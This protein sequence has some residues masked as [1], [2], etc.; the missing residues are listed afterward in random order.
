MKR[1]LFKSGYPA[2][3]RRTVL[4]FV[5]MII[6]PLPQW[7]S[8]GVCGAATYYV[9]P[10]GN[11]RNDGSSTAPFETIQKA[12]DTVR[13]G[14]TV[15]VGDGTYRDSNNDGYIVYLDRGGTSSA[16]VTFK[17]ENKWGAV[18]D[19]QNNK[20]RYCWLNYKKADYVR[21]EDFEIKGCVKGIFSN[22]EN[23]DI[24]VYRN[25]IHDIGRLETYDLDGKSAVHTGKGTYNFTFDSNVIHTIGR[26]NPYTT[27]AV[28]ESSCTTPPK[29]IYNRTVYKDL[30]TCYNHD[31]GLYL[32]GSNHKV[33]NNIFYDMKSGWPIQISGGPSATDGPNWQIMNNTFYGRN[34]RREGHI[35]IWTPARG[36]QPTNVFIA[37]NISD[38]AKAAFIRT[39]SAGTDSWVLSNNLVHGPTSLVYNDRGGTVTFSAVDNI[40]G[41]DPNFVD[42]GNGDFHIRAGSPASA[43]GIKR[44]SPRQDADRNIRPDD[45]LPDLGAY[46]VSPAR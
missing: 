27:P 44:D 26:L 8:A 41:P 23:H 10:G 25:H 12:A 20:T 2:A 21:I 31:Q 5:I 28:P 42:A 24:Y 40:I 36:H 17:S 6:L 15:I 4:L 14:D 22:N 7:I 1:R 32:F 45:K 46:E 16:W 18:L 19:G 39:S 37:N 29:Y 13:P 3:V 33:I 11:D 30:I 38:G 35:E 34:P 9:S 43:K